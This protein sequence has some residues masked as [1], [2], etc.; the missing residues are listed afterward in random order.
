MLRLRH[1]KSVIAVY[2]EGSFTA[3]AAREN[4]TQSGISQHVSAMEARLGQ[5][6]FE[7]SST[8]VAPTEACRRFYEKAVQAIHLLNQAEMDIRSE[9]DAIEGVVNA[10]L[11]PVFTR[12]ILAAVLER[13]TRKHP[14]LDIKISESYSGVL[15]EMVKAEKLDF[16]LVPS[17]I[18]EDGL[19]ISHFARDREVLVCGAEYSARHGLTGFDPVRLAD[20]PPLDIIVPAR[21]N[22]RYQRL[23]E[24]ISTHGVQVNRMMELDSMMGTLELITQGDWVSILPQMLCYNDH[25]A[26]PRRLHP[27]AEPGLHSDFVV[28]TPSRQPLTRQAQFFL[29]E[30]RA[31]F[32]AL[33]E[34]NPTAA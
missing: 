31:E 9:T 4:A 3:A 22:I 19:T 8:G 5:A 17:L 2:E 30:L 18:R 26:G 25:Q 21:T 14:N 12:S 24:Y 7:R 13:S 27:L 16:A 6:L 32:S 34:D 28:I 1:I 29:D 23:N 10:G 11:M 20:L 15:T 33:Y